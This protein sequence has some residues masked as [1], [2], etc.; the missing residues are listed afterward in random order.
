MPRGGGRRLATGSPLTQPPFPPSAVASLHRGPT[1]P[2]RRTLRPASPGT[3]SLPPPRGVPRRPLA[4]RPRAARRRLDARAD[5]RAGARAAAV[6]DVDS[7]GPGAAHVRWASGRVEV[8][9]RHLAVRHHH[10][11]LALRVVVGRQLAAAAELDGHQAVP[12]VGALGRA[13]RQ[14]RARVRRQ[15]AGPLLWRPALVR[16][17]HAPLVGPGAHGQQGA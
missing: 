1:A 17:G 10:V 4:L 15:R 12:T 6:G 5:A 2:D 7:G 8:H 9:E 3:G 11:Q 14:P 13:V 16:H